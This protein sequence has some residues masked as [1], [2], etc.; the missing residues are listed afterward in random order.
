V[1]ITRTHGDYPELI[2]ILAKARKNASLAASAQ[3]IDD[4]L[5][6]AYYRIGN[7]AA[8][9]AAYRDEV[10]AISKSM[11]TPGKPLGAPADALLQKGEA[12]WLSGD[13]AT[14]RAD[15]LTA[16]SEFRGPAGSMAAN[17]LAYFESLAGVDLPE[18]ESLSRAA[19][20]DA[21]KAGDTGVI[22]TYRDTLGWILHDEH[23][24]KEAI[25]QLQ[26]AAADMP[27][28]T[29]ILFHL[30]TVYDSLGQADAARIEYQRVLALQPF[31]AAARDALGRLVKPHRSA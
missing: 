31:N 20:A 24:D 21:E 23:R 12:E 6:D 25:G 17:N 5:G 19:V 13:R 26:L 8:S 3:D 7:T 30:A 9:Q 10:A 18:A 4:T 15:M 22:A 11:A 14:G 28:L 29:D 1:D 16:R 27:Q 2:N